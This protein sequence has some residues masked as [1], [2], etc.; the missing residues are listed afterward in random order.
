MK[1]AVPRPS[2]IPAYDSA[3]PTISSSDGGGAASAT[4]G[5]GGIG[6]LPITNTKLPLVV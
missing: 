1:N 3:R 4:W 5:T 2:A 6:P